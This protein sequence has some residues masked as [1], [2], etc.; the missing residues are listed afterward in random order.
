V[1]LESYGISGTLLTWLRNFFTCRMQCTKVGTVLSDLTDLISGV[2][3]GSVLGLLM[4]LAYLSE[5]AE[6]LEKFGIAVNFFADDVKLYV[7]IMLMLICF[8]ML[9]MPFVDGPKSGSCPFLLISVVF[10][11]LA[12]VFA[13]SLFLDLLIVTI[14]KDL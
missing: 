10:S 8:K 14:H 12:N 5:L 9:L 4:F 2:I 7:K 6:I 13:M 11:I 1:R 3:Q